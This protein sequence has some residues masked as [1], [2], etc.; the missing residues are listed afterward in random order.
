MGGRKSGVAQKI[1]DEDVGTG[2][3]DAAMQPAQHHRHDQR[4]QKQ[5][6][7]A[8][9]QSRRRQSPAAR[10]FVFMYAQIKK[11]EEEKIEAIEEIVPARQSAQRKK[12]GCA[13]QPGVALAVQRQKIAKDK[14]GQKFNAR[15]MGMMH[16]LGDV[17]GT[18]GED[19]TARCRADHAAAQIAA[20][21]EGSRARQ[22]KGSQDRDVLQPHK[23]RQRGA[24]NLAQDPYRKDLRI[25]K[26]VIIKRDAFGRADQ[27]REEEIALMRLDGIPAVPEVL[28]IVFRRPQQRRGQ[29]R[30]GLPEEQCRQRRERGQHDKKFRRP[31]GGHVSDRRI[32]F[33]PGP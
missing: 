33:S 12:D 18:E 20:K 6:R 22:R 19:E 7:A 32:D 14:E 28:Q 31:P 16:R 25:S 9:A 30:Q 13:G 21:I 24:E 11:M 5:C 23:R 27:A 15:D 26:G 10:P 4:R 1:G 17:P 8:E 2:L 29:M 3:V